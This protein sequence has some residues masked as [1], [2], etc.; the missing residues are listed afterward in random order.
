MVMNILSKLIMGCAVL[1]NLP[2]KHSVT[3]C[4]VFGGS[5]ST[6]LVT[7]HLSAYRELLGF[8]YSS[9]SSFFSLELKV[10]L[11]ILCFT[12]YDR[13]KSCKSGWYHSTYD[14]GSVWTL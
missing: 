2:C 13:Q 11:L 4:I 10:A 14:S 8:W 12:F 3:I 6:P 5:V 7:F 9:S 1:K